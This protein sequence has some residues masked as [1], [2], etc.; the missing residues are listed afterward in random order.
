MSTPKN[1]GVK[2]AAALI[3]SGGAGTLAVVNV[4]DG[5]PFAT[6]VNV[7]ADAGARPVILISGLSHHSQCLKA[8]PRAAIMLHAALPREG[9]PLSILRVTLTGIFRTVTVEEEDVRALFLARHPYAGLYAGFG[10]F[11]FWRMEPAHA[12]IIAGFGRAYSVPF[13]DIAA[14]G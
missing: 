13:S 6:L 11:A 9:D 10:D 1:E 8:D 3:R 12:H 7:A 4:K 5:G 2:S 14:A